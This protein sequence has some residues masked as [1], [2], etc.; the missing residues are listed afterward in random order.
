EATGGAGNRPHW[1]VEIALPESFGADLIVHIHP[2]SR[3]A[4]RSASL[5]ELHADRVVLPASVLAGRNKVTIEV[6]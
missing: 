1:R 4:L 6:S 5:G 2:P 3:E